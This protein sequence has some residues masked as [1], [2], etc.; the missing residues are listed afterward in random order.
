MRAPFVKICCIS[1]VAE[2]RTAIDHGASAIGL[3]SAMPSGPGVISEKL[4]AEIADLVPPPIATFLLTSLQDADSIVEQ[5]ARCRT[6]T[7]QL[8]DHVDPDEL[9]QVRSML[10]GIKLVQVIH[11]HDAGSINEA[12]DASIFVDA[13]LLDSGNNMLPVKELG[14]TGRTHDWTVSRQIR[15]RVGV[16]LFLAGGLNAE[17]AADAIAAVRPSGLDLCSG[18]R[19]N[20]ALDADKLRRFMAVTRGSVQ[21]F[22]PW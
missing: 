19:T 6:T 14:G 12:M 3:V 15:E 11:V 17:N 4:I 22:A 16:P 7:I 9:R 8:V 21:E 1:S 13:L 18:V 20:G 10:P 2:A 5:H